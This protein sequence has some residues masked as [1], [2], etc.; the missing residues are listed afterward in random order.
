MPEL[1]GLR[2]P[3]SDSPRITVRHL[4]SHAEG[5]PEDNPWGDQQLSA[6]DDQF[7]AMVRGGIPFSNPPGVAYEYSNYGFAIL[8][9]I[10]TPRIGNALQNLRRHAHPEAIGHDVDHPRTGRGGA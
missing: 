2:Y 3:T 9:R 5:F 1:A 10:V 7:T 4:L 8:G 6:T